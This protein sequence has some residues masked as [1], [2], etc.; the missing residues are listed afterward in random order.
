[1]SQLEAIFFRTNQVIT[2]HD[3]IPLLFKK[4]HQKQHYY[5]E[6]LL[7]HTLRM[8][9][10][11]ITP[12]QHTKGL[13]ELCY[14]L[15]PA[16]VRVIHHGARRR[17]RNGPWLGGPPKPAFIL[18]AGRTVRM[19]N[20]AG[21]LK[22]FEL[23]KDLVDHQ[24]VITGNG[25]EHWLKESCCRIHS[26]CSLTTDRVLFKGTVSSE[27][28][29]N[30][31]ER[32]SLLVF[33]S[34]YE[35]FGLPPLEAMASGCPV[36]VSTAA[37]LP[38]VCGDAAYYINPHDVGSIAEGM[39]R[40]LTD[41]ALRDQLTRRGI[42]RAKLFS[43]EESA[44]SHLGALEDALALAPSVPRQSAY[45]PGYAAS[46]RQSSPVGAY[47]LYRMGGQLQE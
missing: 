14:G 2:I 33:P 29:T 23:I 43:W 34:F 6:Y 24:L 3:L 36:V 42:E 21:V 12:S 15:D 27:E 30:L 10:V 47:N 45:E 37:S 46:W 16:K 22:A 19:K 39:Y 26:E 20:V 41:S 5:Y 38:E 44:K 31:L 17:E 8:A 25:G 28:M 11:V 1:M 40:V 18:Y 9:K 7:P 32:A 4:C 35:G 13:L